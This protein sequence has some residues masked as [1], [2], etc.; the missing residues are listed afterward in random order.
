MGNEQPKATKDDGNDQ[1]QQQTQTMASAWDNLE[2]EWEDFM[3]E[4]DFGDSDAD[5][6][7]NNGSNNHSSHHQHQHH[8][9]NRELTTIE[10]ESILNADRKQFEFVPPKNFIRDIEDFYDIRKQLGKG[11][12]CTVLLVSAKTTV[13][14]AAQPLSLFALKELPKS[15]ADNELLFRHEI[16]IMNELHAR[17]E[18]SEHHPHLVRYIDCYVSP[19]CYYIVLEYEAGGTMLERILKR[20]RFSERDAAHWINTILV[21]VEHIHSL[22]IVHRDLKADNFIFNTT[23]DDSVLKVIDFGGYTTNILI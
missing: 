10:I 19:L 3:A 14:T 12:S 17:Y 22:D 9:N 16:Q 6:N 15:H 21:A 7:H 2:H 20:D 11:A 23:A 5:D 13:D 4:E 18:P 1:Q 8:N